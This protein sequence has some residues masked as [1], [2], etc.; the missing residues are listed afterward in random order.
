M[1]TLTTDLQT[2]Q[3]HQYPHVT[4]SASAKSASPTQIGPWREFA[5][6]TNTATGTLNEICTTSTGDILRFQVTASSITL[7]TIAAANVNSAASWNATP[8]TILANGGT[9]PA[10]VRGG[11]FYPQTV[12]LFYVRSGVVYYI[13]STNNGSTWGS[14]TTFWTPGGVYSNPGNLKADSDTTNDC[15][16]LAASVDVSGSYSPSTVL[17]GAPYAGG[18]VLI[19]TVI[20]EQEIPIGITADDGEATIYVTCPNTTQRSYLKTS[21]KLI[22]Y[23]P[24]T[25]AW[26]SETDLATID[27]SPIIAGTTDTIISRGAL[28]HDENSQPFMLIG[29]ELGWKAYPFA[30]E[31]RHRSALPPLDYTTALPISTTA[32]HASGIVTASIVATITSAPTG[33]PIVCTATRTTRNAT[34]ATPI[35]YKLTHNLSAGARLDI[36]LQPLAD[37][38]PGDYIHVTRTLS[39][40]TASAS[41]TLIFRAMRIETH[42]TR[43]LVIAYDRLGE[44]AYRRARK[45]NALIAADAA[46][47]L[48]AI[49]ALLHRAGMTTPWGIT[50]TVEHIPP[51]FTWMIGESAL[52]ALLRYTGYGNVEL[53]SHHH[54]GTSQH[55]MITVINLSDMTDYTYGDDHDYIDYVAIEDGRDP[56]AAT[57]IGKQTA[58]LS[59]GRVLEHRSLPRLNTLPHSTQAELSHQFTATEAEQRADALISHMRAFRTDAILTTTPNLVQEVGDLVSVFVGEDEFSYYVLAIEETYDRG[60]LT[61]KLTLSEAI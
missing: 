29:I 38:Q 58:S 48:A 46:D 11:Q 3:Q 28:I 60:R 31:W 33:N 8:T 41:D 1:R 10:A 25:M 16:L 56:R 42:G 37:I 54:T 47:N 57:I 27:R 43:T 6:V 40:P 5:S 23:N 14:E 53:R 34:L 18:V 21:S 44:L 35:K 52:S 26:I 61:Q 9:S 17:L 59:D 4:V 51:V 45:S 32:N 36:D 7:T 2:I 50:P 22:T 12:R 20:D 30:S 39:L 19:T 13:Q 15:W 24:S 55:D 49:T